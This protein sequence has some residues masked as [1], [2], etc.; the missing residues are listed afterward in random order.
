MVAWCYEIEHPLSHFLNLCHTTVRTSVVEGPRL[1]VSM[2]SCDSERGAMLSGSETLPRPVANSQGL[3]R[4]ER[5]IV[6]RS[7]RA[8]VV[9]DNPVVL[10]SASRLLA[11]FPTIELVGQATSGN[12]AL[13]VVEKLRPDLVL[14]DI[15][16][17]GMDGLEATRRLV[18]KDG[19]PRVILMSMHDIPE[20]RDAAVVAGAV[21]F[22]S[23]SALVEELSTVVDEVLRGFE[24]AAARDAGPA[25]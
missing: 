16:M 22:V 6:G 11:K 19:A 3:P 13:E 20:Y 14:M 17:P 1:A 9:D 4:K 2:T 21:C 25:E 24:S 8:I 10:K 5:R 7:L 15:S 18:L 23:K 12:E